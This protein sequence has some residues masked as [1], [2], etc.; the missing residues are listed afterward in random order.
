VRNIV[1]GMFDA[2]PTMPAAFIRL[3]FHDCFVMVCSALASL[4]ISS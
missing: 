2:D 1:N 4:S 3:L